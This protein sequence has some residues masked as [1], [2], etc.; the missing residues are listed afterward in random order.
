MSIR[1]PRVRMITFH[2]CHCL[3][4][5][6]R[7]VQYRILLCTASSSVSIQP[8]MRFLFV[9]A[10][11]CVRLPSDSTSRWTPLSFAN[12]S[13]C[14]ACSGLSPPSYHPCRAHCEEPSGLRI[15]GSFFCFT[16]S[17]GERALVGGEDVV[18]A[19]APAVSAYAEEKSIRYSL[20]LREN[21]G[22]YLR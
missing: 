19:S 11:I 15:L 8:Y 10:S 17:F 2:S 18:R 7:F 13:Y 3:I 16:L 5:C 21:G 9:S 1:P 4:Y 12:S 6:K 20:N 14:K 22:C